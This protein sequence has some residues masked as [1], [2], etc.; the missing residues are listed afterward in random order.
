M[1]DTDLDNGAIAVTKTK[2]LR[3]QSMWLREGQRE[4]Q[5]E[6]EG[7]A[8]TTVYRLS[9]GRMWLNR[10]LKEAR[11][12]KYKYLEEEHSRYSKLK[13]QRPWVKNILW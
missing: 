13:V 5:L 6:V 4:G 1:P 3:S 11:E 7:G 2:P 10:D 9:E 8:V 12:H